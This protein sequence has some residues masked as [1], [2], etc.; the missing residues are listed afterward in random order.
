MNTELPESLPLNA[1]PNSLRAVSLNTGFVTRLVSYRLKWSTSCSCAILFM[2][3]LGGRLT[4]AVYAVAMKER[5][6]IRV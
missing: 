6:Q 4:K 3:D 5:A 1:K 2:E